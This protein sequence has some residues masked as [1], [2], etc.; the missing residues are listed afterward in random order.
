MLRILIALSIASA[1]AASS[2]AW[3]QGSV[4]VQPLSTAVDTAAPQADAPITPKDHLEVTVFR[5]PDLSVADVMVDESGHVALPLVG[6]FMAAGKSTAALSSEISSKLKQYLTQPEVA[7]TLKQAATRQVTVTGSVVQPGVYPIEGRL[8]LLQAV[9]LARGPS[10]VASMDDAFIFRTR[11]GQR[12]AARFNLDAIAK[13]KAT[14]PEV[15]PGD[16]ITVG[17]S[18]VKTAWRDVLET[19]RS[20]NIFR[21]LP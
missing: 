13:A 5:E 3:A 12:S 18:G 14:D 15:L 2:P 6:S 8:T 16:T 1:G 20:F 19:V 21:V 10:Q 7:V 11:D 9:A 4:P 17:S